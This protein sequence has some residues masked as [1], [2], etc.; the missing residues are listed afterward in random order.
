[1][2]GD[3][4]LE[5]GLIRGFQ[6]E[7][8]DES[9]IAK[10]LSLSVL[11][12]PE[13]KE[14]IGHYEFH[15]IDPE[16]AMHYSQD[17]VHEDICYLTERYFKDHPGKDDFRMNFIMLPVTEKEFD[18]WIETGKFSAKATRNAIER[19]SAGDVSRSL[20]HLL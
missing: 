17:Q 9:P 6:E 15:D 18:F 10:H 13:T 12:H 14:S 4:E 5:I 8:D 3:D 2:D 19:I 11:Y 7:S 20:V 1:M 16:Y